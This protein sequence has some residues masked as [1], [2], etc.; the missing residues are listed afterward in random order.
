MNLLPR[1]KYPLGRNQKSMAL[2]ISGSNHN[3]IMCES[4]ACKQLVSEKMDE[5]CTEALAQRLSR[6]PYVQQAL[7]ALLPRLAAFNKD[8]FV[9]M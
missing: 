2:V 9:S 3:Q 7:L 8:K 6:S 5:I 4:S 1:L